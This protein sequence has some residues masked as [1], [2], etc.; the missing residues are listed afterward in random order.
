MARLPHAALLL[1]LL[2]SCGGGSSSEDTTP[3]EIGDGYADVDDG[4]ALQALEIP[5][6][7][8]RVTFLGD[9]ITAGLHLSVDRAWPAA[10][11]RLLFGEGLP[12]HVQNAGVSGDTTASGRS[13]LDWVLKSEPDIVVVELG[14]NNGLRGQDL[15]AV[16]EDLRAILQK[17]RDAGARPV[18][19]GMNVPTNF[20][21][22]DDFAAI[23]PRVAES[24]GVP[25]VSRFLEGV[26]GVPEMN[27][28]DGLHPTP[29]GHERLAANVADVLRAELQALQAVPG[30]G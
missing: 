7:A 4:P 17:V 15:P 9:S 25:L 10:L 6:D 18:L 5:E 24:M 14:A 12:F 22:A 28:P 23:Y 8:P 2:A 1:A 3:N 27:L 11:Q 20:D 21:F 16:E 13:R 29:E 26:G 19:I 30:D